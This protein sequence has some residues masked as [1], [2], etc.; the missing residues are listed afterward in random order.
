MFIYSVNSVAER[1]NNHLVETHFYTCIFPFQSRLMLLLMLVILSTT[2]HLPLSMANFLYYRLVMH[3]L[4][5][6][7]RVFGCTYFVHQLSL[8]SDKLSLVNQVFF[9]LLSHLKGYPCCCYSQSCQDFVSAKMTF[10]KFTI[11]FHSTPSL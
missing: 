2:N 11:C 1:M 8:E 5:P 10:F 9:F 6:R 4:P 7:P 3:P